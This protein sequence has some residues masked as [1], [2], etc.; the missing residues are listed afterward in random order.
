MAVSRPL[1]APDPDAEAQRIAAHLAKI[2]DAGRA[3]TLTDAQR[4]QLA[5]WFRYSP[6]P[7]EDTGG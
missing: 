5:R 1:P 4:E 2:D 7:G 3:G 6:P